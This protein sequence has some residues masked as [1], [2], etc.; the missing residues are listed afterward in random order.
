VVGVLLLGL[1]A[2]PRG[3]PAQATPPDPLALTLDL[4]FVNTSGNTEV[5][6]FNT[7]EKVVVTSAPWTVTQT[8][9]VVYGRIAD[10]TTTSQW[11]AGA[12]GEFGLSP[13]LGMFADARYERNRF[14]GIARRFE[15][16]LGLSAVPVN[17]GGNRLKVEAGAS[18]NQQTSFVTDTT[19][20]FAAGRASAEYRRQITETSHLT[21]TAEFLPNFKTS[22]DYRVN[23][24]ATLVAPIS[25]K[26]AVKLSYDARFDHLPEPGFEK[27]DR[28]LTA[29]L[30]I[31]F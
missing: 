14:A 29:G 20:T 26:V 1:L 28:I 13:R 10:S 9:A 27:W 12:R 8:F 17:A 22:D 11:K 5:T 2:V 31:V 15:E 24:V 18:L 25:Q 21:I 7:G 6:T 4:G 23:G 3:A 30:Q 19:A 16:A